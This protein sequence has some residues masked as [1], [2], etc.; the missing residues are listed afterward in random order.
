MTHEE[1]LAHYTTKM[2]P[3][4]LP[5]AI[6]QVDITDLPDKVDWREHGLVTEVKNQGQ[7]G[8][9]WSFSTT[10]SIEGAHA[11]ATGKLVSLSEQQLVECDRVDQACNGGLMDHGFD[12]VIKAGGLVTEQSYPY[13]APEISKCKFNKDNIAANISS[14]KD[15]EHGS[16][17]DLQKAVAEVGPISVA[18][19]A[20]HMSFQSYRSGVYNPLLC[21]ST[22]LDHGVLAVGY[23]QEA[24]GLVSKEHD[25]WLVKNSWGSSWGMHGYIKMIRN[26][27]NKCGIATM[28]SYP[29]V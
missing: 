20:S 25:Y 3:R 4:Q 10:G 13:T 24:G 18:I 7:C 16:E 29:I 12:Y 28:A 1:F 23:G 22:R 2:A 6:K 17:T 11:K 15:I 14:Y 26:K 9:C 19:D 21:S 8:S 5:E 27:N